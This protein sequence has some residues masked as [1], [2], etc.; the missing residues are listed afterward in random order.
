MEFYAA[1]LELKTVLIT[2]PWLWIFY[3]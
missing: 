2:F 1:A 3:T